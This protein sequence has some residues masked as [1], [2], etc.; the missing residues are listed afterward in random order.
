MRE[1]V[2]QHTKENAGS[3]VTTGLTLQ[4]K[5]DCGNHTMSGNCDDCAK[6]TS[7][8]QRK[9]LSGTEPVEAPG[10]VHE[11]LRSPGQPLDGNTRGFMES[12]LGHDFSKVRVHADARAE[13]SAGAVSAEAYTVRNHVVFGAGKYQPATV[14][15]RQLIA[16]ELV[17]VLQQGEGPVPSRMNLGSESS[18]LEHQAH[19]LSADAMAMFGKPQN[20]ERGSEVRTSFAN[21]LARSDLPALDAPVGTI[22]RRRV[23]ESIGLQAATPMSGAAF[24]ATRTGLAR[25][26]SRAWAG[27]SAPNQIAVQTAMGVVGLTWTT[28]ANLRTTLETATR[29]QLIR[30]GQ[31]IRTVEPTAELGSPLL[32]DTG[33]RPA[34]ADAANITTL[35]G[36]A[37]AIF[38]TLA[39]TTRDADLTQVF[40]AGNEATAKTKYNNAKTQMDALH[41][42]NKIVTDRSG[43]SGEV[44]LGGLSNSDQISVEPSV[45]DNPTANESVVTLIHESMHAGNTD[46]HDFGY[47]DQPSFTVLDHPVKLTNAAHFE[48][49]PR[50]ILG[51]SNSFPG[52]TFTP[53]GSGGTPVLTARE[54]A[55]RDASET[56]RAAWTVGL[57]LHTIFVRLFRR[58]SEWNTLDLSTAFSGAPAGAH[59]ADTL[60]FWSKVE[61]LTIHTRPVINPTGLPDEQP[62]TL[63]DIAL[64]EGLI[65]KLSQGMNSVPATPADALALENAS[66]SLS[67]RTAAAASVAAE[68][69]L[70]IRLVIRV[71]LGSL[72]GSFIRD[73]QVVARMAQANLPDFSD[74]LAVRPPGAFP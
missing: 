12:S 68:R 37:N 55:I 21:D 44:G 51:A 49:V 4:R 6:K 3:F 66:A 7:A 29:T 20:A 30:L 71:N 8:L 72:T 69:D 54:Q 73:E 1:A 14:D 10:I 23:P 70:L 46:V 15:G 58:P 41:S 74:M 42:T 18:P 26:L 38:A 16:H 19:N 47:I 28:E 40:G 39:G 31:E 67:E 36:N 27:L 52:V 13:A 24:D 48:V 61:R 56:Y 9:A 45:I 60:P 35:V 62:I 64:S 25:L 33:P 57:N 50:R 5:C 11:V 63:I 22:Q 43:Y 59:F 32:I 65:R 53:A 34:T 2:L 17:H